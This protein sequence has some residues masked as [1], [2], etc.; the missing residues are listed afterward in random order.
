MPLVFAVFF[1]WRRKIVRWQALTLISVFFVAAIGWEVWLTYGMAGGL[2]VDAR[3]SDALNCAVPKNLNWVLNSLGDVMIAWIGIFL[4]GLYYRKKPSPFAKWHWPAFII[5]L[6]WCLAQNI[7]VEAFFY[8][9]QL[10]ENGDLS[11]APLHP[12]GSWFNPT[13]FKIAGREITL[14]AQMIWMFMTPIIYAIA[15]YFY[16]R[17]EVDKADRMKRAL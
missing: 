13:L 2:P 1:A 17:T 15:I 4:I 6:V 12:L 5:L 7:Y 3:R 16:R 9:M 8:H 10:G 14:Q 11:W